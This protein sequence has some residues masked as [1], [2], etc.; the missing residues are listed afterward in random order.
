MSIAERIGGEGKDP[1]AVRHRKLRKGA[2]AA[3]IGLPLLPFGPGGGHPSTRRALYSIWTGA[4]GSP[5]ELTGR[6]EYRR[7]APMTDGL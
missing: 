1:S 5:T 4:G 7:R 3:Q 2:A 6:L